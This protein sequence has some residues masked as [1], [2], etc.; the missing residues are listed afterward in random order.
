MHTGSIDSLNLP[1]SSN[2]ILKKRVVRQPPLLR[3]CTLACIVSHYRASDKIDSCREGQPVTRCAGRMR[4][5]H[6]YYEPRRRT[7]AL[8][9]PAY[10]TTNSLFNDGDDTSSYLC[11]F[12]SF[13]LPLA[14]CWSSKRCAPHTH[15]G[16]RTTRSSNFTC[17]SPR[18][19]RLGGDLRLC[20]P[21]PDHI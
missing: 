1:T 10:C 2:T 8:A 9:D 6:V 21:I 15:Q 5:A 7:T 3:D 17:D 20:E 16:L 12:P 11:T 18:L 4:H 14:F 13:V 19:C